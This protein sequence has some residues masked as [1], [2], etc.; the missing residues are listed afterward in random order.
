[1]DREFYTYCPLAR[2]KCNHGELS[3]T[4]KQEDVPV[5]AFYDGDDD[6]CRITDA[7][8]ALRSLGKACDAD[9]GY[10]NISGGIDTY[11]QN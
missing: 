5:C 9:I 6:I 4:P 3:F 1:M 2:A 8:N 7:L 11:E 10:L